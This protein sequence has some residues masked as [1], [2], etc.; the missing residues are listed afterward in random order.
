MNHSSQVI[1]NL[2]P[3][4]NGDIE[5]SI[6]PDLYSS[7]VIL[8]MDDNTVSQSSVDVPIA[9][10]KIDKRD[11]S[12]SKPLDP[13]K[14]YNEMRDAVLIKNSEET[15]IDD[16]TS[17]EYM[18]VD[19]L[20]KVVQVQEAINNRKGDSFGLHT[21][22][23]L[24]DWDTFSE[25]EKNTKYSK[26]MSN[27]VNFF[28]Y[29]KDHDYFTKVVKPFIVN[30]MEKSFIDFWLIGDHEAVIKHRSLKLLNK[31]NAFEKCLLVAELM[32]NNDHT[33][34]AKAL[35]DNLKLVAKS[36]EE[37][38]ESRNRIFDIIINLHIENEEDEGE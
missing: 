24:K 9:E 37:I 4:E 21:L 18:I 12:L 19:S 31:I 22:S 32:K 5:C 35:A 25:E 6:N 2:Q 26:F 3:N 15:I 1:T 30:K 7:V 27:E 10:E 16:I 33:D 17:T 11:L 14:Y 8:A 34:E 28:L 36:R 29:F 20:E 23:F 38:I 13:E